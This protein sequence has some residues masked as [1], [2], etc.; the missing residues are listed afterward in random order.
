MKTKPVVPRARAKRP[1]E[2]KLIAFLRRGAR[3]ARREERAYRG[4]VSDEQRSEP[5]WIGAGRPVYFPAVANQDVEEAIAYYV[6]EDAAQAALGFIDA[7]EKAYVH[8]ARHPVAGSPRY[9]HE[10]GI[11][12]LRTWQLTRS[13][14]LV[15]YVERDDH[16]DVWRVLHG[17]RDVRRTLSSP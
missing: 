6:A 7:L 15:F 8:L 10:L 12:G 5:G 14:Y 11:P 2:N 9:A 4:Y 17:Q 1:A 13:P 16:V 3:L